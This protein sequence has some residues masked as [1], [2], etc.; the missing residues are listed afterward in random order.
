MPRVE[1]T[2]M[3]PS[4]D[5]RLRRHTAADPEMMKQALRRP[6]LRKQEVE[7][8]LGKRRKNME[9]DEMGDLRGRIHVGKQDLGKLQ[10]R[11]MKGLKA[12]R[13]EDVEMADE[14][15]GDGFGIG[16]EEEEGRDRRKKRR[17]A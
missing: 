14:E 8:G 12:G 7:K 16:E 9:V 2:P 4:L 6:K 13:D 5:I 11:K 10:T 15:D 17:A 1:L 3:G